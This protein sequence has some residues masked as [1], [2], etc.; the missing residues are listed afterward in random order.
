MYRESMQLFE[1][2]EWYEELGDCI[3]F[4]FHDMASPPDATCGIPIQDSFDDAY[5]THYVVIDFN[6]LYDQVVTQST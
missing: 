6:N 4:H 3:F 5:W 2:S 1:T